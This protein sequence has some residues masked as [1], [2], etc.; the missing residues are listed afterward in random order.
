[1]TEERPT[2]N[3]SDLKKLYASNSADE[4]AID[5]C[6]T[7]RKAFVKPMKVRD[8]KDILKAIESKDEKLIQ[9]VFDD[10]V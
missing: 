9:K 7:G 10:I 4:M 1:M 5:L 3:M 2:F 8:K 6:F